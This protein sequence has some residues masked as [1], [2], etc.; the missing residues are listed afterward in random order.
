MPAVRLI[1]LATVAALAL[2]P[3]A[4]AVTASQP[5]PGSAGESTFVPGELLVRFERGVNGTERGEL[6]RDQGLLFER[7]L[8]L[9]GVQLVQTDGK[10]VAAAAA[11]L[12]REQGV[13]YAEPNYIYRT[14]A[15]PNDPGFDQLWGLNSTG[16][17][18]AGTSGT[19]DADVDAPEAW[20]VTTGAAG[21]V[22]AVVD[23]GL[24]QVHPDL[25]PNVWANPGETAGNGADDDGN[26][27][28]DDA[29]G[30]D[31]VGNSPNPTDPNGHGSHIAGTIGARGNDG[32]GVAGLNWQVSL[33]PVRAT[34]A[35]GGATA[36]QVA[37]GLAY[38]G[39]EGARVANV[40]LGAPFASSAIADAV[41][42]SPNT[43]FVAAAD[44][45]GADG[46]GDNA[47]VV[48]DFPCSLPAP[49]LVCVAASD[50]NDNLTAFSNFGPTSVDLAA[51]GVAIG[52]TIPGNRYAVMSGTSFA[53]PHVAGVAALLWSRYPSASVAFVRDA[54][55]SRVDPKPGMAGRIASG[56]RLNASSSVSVPP[57]PPP[58][59]APPAPPTPAAV[60]AAASS[61]PL[62]SLPG[63][64]A[65]AL[66][67]LR[68]S[69]LRVT[70]RCSGR[71]AVRVRLL[72]GRGLARRLRLAIGRKSG[73]AVAAR[74]SATLAGPGTT[75]VLVRPTREGR[76]RLRR[77]RTLAAVLE[78]QI[79]EGEPRPAV[80]T[81][82]LRLG[83]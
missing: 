25:A 62:V 40:S 21:T 76:K 74:G 3:P 7:N 14:S 56:G 53:T 47:D 66:R 39:A 22:V 77:V 65:R 78:T 57:P 35:S 64:S 45:G 10:P 52:S 68:S 67:A 27:Y 63:G 71:C 28:V 72:V 46:V 20:D 33:M 73:Y 38:A 4:Q 54:L 31:F 79:S 26:G 60:A 18:V 34:N 5:P 69:G 50:R 9:P 2:V 30:W 70:V 61:S 8:P 44:N 19:P 41:A 81:R 80:H 16:Q 42:R 11:A 6:R 15:I 59:Q 1:L 83:R 17:A 55:L 37:A 12:E 51:P 36:A 49:N 75:T 29:R 48:G 13:A 24:D 23:T 32:A 82:R 43:L 58:P